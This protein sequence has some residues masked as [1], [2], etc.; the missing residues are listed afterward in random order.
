MRPNPNDFAP[1]YARYIELVPEDDVLT[2][3]ESQSAETQRLLAS[4][5]ETRA[6]FRYAPEKWSVKQVV[7]HFT[8]AERIFG[9]RMHAISRGE[10]Q[11]LPGFDENAYVANG[12]FDAWKI[13]DLAEHYALARRANIVLLRN[14]AEDA[15]DRRGLANGVP[16]TVRA[17]AFLTV[18]HE[19]HHLRVLR[20]KYLVA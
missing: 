1:Y 4:V 8:D 11:S 14:L 6:A 19:R 7:G 10:Q 3:M 17:I 16:V 15:W 2:A 13:G 18:G 9:S 12:G 20:E 5:D